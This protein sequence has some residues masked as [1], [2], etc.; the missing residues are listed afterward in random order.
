MKKIG[1]FVF[2]LL[3]SLAFVS[4]LDPSANSNDGSQD[5]NTIQNYTN[6]IPI[7]DSGKFDSGKITSFNKS[8]AELRIE[9]INGYVGPISSL[10]I[11]RELTMSMLFVY[12]LLV[13][14]LLAE[15]ISA[16]ISNLFGVKSFVAVLI[17]LL[18]SSLAMHSY[19]QNLVIWLDT[20]TS[21]WWAAVLAIVSAVVVGVI[22][23]AIMKLLGKNMEKAKEASAK[24][25][26]EKDREIIHVDAETSEKKLKSYDDSNNE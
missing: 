24:E 10:V 3:F 6:Q 17:A 2:I 4:S 1:V 20:I 11:G 9:K 7:D 18:I 23:A 19:A 26:L 14:L 16:P 12:A 22:Y 8:Q 25:Q 13:W 5:M 21:A 15:F